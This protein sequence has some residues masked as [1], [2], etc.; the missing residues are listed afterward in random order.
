ME[1]VKQCVKVKK[2]TPSKEELERLSQRIPNDWK[3]LGRR[4]EVEDSQLIAFDKENDQCCE[5]GY[6]MLMFWKQ[7]DFSG[8]TYQV[9]YDA[10][11]H[12]LVQLQE[13]AEKFCCV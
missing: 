2:G 9:L 7:R 1:D 4:L 8:A 5:K 10:L 6:S 13:L 11:C 3:K 12:E